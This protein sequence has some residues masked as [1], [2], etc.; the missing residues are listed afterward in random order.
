MISVSYLLFFITKIVQ[1]LLIQLQNQIG[2]WKNQESIINQ[3]KQ[4]SLSSKEIQILRCAE[5]MFLVKL[6]LQA[7]I[8]QCI[9]ISNDLHIYIYVRKVSINNVWLMVRTYCYIFFISYTWW[10]IKIPFTK[11]LTSKT[12]AVWKKDKTVQFFL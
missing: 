3:L 5:D 12:Q 2:F 4:S 1:V 11:L 7:N 9:Y 6:S 10:I 8:N